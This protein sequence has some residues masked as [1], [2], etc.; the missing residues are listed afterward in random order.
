MSEARDDKWE[1]SPEYLLWD[2]W[3]AEGRFV[4]D[5]DQWL[6]DRL[7]V[8]STRSHALPKSWICACGADD[9]KKCPV[10]EA[11]CVGGRDTSCTRSTIATRRASFNLSQA[12]QLL[13]MFG[14][15][16]TDI[17]VEWTDGHSGF[18][19]YAFYSEYPEEGYELLDPKRE[20]P[21]L[22]ETT[23]SAIAPNAE[24][25]RLREIEH[26]AW[27]ALDACEQRPHDLLIPLDE[28]L[29]LSKLLPDAH[30]EYATTDGGV[31]E[32]P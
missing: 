6:H 3:M 12:T 32:K 19:M 25:E 4:D 21:K 13:Q 14:G 8:F 29:A 9:P 30:P 31:K 1:S 15:E 26:A 23:A 18:G 5:R 10:D 2:E 11:R 20:P 27:H 7:K 17:T 16:E 22:E 24:I 28:G